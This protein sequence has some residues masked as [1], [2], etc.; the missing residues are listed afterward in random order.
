ML[1]FTTYASRSR[2][3]CTELTIAKT[4]AKCRDDVSGGPRSAVEAMDSK[5]TSRKWAKE[6]YFQTINPAKKLAADIRRWIAD[7]DS[8][9]RGSE[10]Q[11]WRLT[12]A[13][14]AENALQSGV[15]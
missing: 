4:R 14:C 6:K 10:P 13:P 8:R 9:G 7:V 11:T 12:P 5:T 15:F 2:K 3:T 1:E